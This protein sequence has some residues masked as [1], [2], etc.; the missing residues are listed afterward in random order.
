MIHEV[1]F[2]EETRQVSGE[3]SHTNHVLA[4]KT[5][6]QWMSEQKIIYDRGG[7]PVD[8]EFFFGRL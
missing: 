1:Q 5:Q 6:E 7:Q 8:G 2:D 4:R 3:I